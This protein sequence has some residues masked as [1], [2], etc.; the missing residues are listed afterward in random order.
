VRLRV[1][2]CDGMPSETPAFSAR[3]KAGVRM[4][5]VTRYLVTRH[6]LAA[7]TSLFTTYK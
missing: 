3:S 7:I 2:S 5:L 6:Y 1:G 4:N